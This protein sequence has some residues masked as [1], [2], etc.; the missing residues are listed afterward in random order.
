MQPCG[1]RR[2][3]DPT[4][5]TW[6]VVFQAEF[7]SLPSYDPDDADMLVVVIETP[8]GSRN[9]YAFDPDERVFT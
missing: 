7:A 4:W 8:K 5:A 1:E 9:K 2:K 6:D 3:L